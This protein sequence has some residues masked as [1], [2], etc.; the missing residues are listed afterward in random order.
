MAL[1]NQDFQLSPGETWAPVVRWAS[2]E[3]TSVPVTGVTSAA[4]VVVTAPG[5]GLPNGWRAALT[6]V[7][8][9]PEVNAANYPPVGE[10]WKRGTVIDA[11][12]VQLNHET[13]AGFGPYVSG[14]FLVYQTPI[15]LDGVG[16][17]LNVWA[18]EDRCGTPIVSLAVG[19]GVTI[20]TTAMTIT[21]RLQTAG[22]AWQT[23]FYSMMATDA[24]GNTTE[25]MAGVLNIQ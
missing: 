4:P 9:M 12:T 10:D 24:S 11:N 3:L 5:H 7:V 21:G 23:G 16:V 17:A 2:D 20:D 15:P 8:G 25:L 18:N 13:G 6:G 19:T 22:L 1:I 14:G